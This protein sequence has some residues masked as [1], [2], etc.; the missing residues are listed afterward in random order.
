LVGVFQRH[1]RGRFEVGKLNDDLEGMVS[2]QL[3]VKEVIL[4]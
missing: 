2:P 4:F 3:R 1:C